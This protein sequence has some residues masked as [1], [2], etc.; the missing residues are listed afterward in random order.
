M[1]WVAGN[2]SFT[3]SMMLNF[4]NGFAISQFNPDNFLFIKKRDNSSGDII[5]LYYIYN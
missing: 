1:F 3:N 2:G 5:I 4:F